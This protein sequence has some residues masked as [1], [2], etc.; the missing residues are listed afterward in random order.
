M[1]ELSIEGTRCGNAKKENWCAVSNAAAS[2]G[3][4]EQER[5]RGGGNAYAYAL[6]PEDQY[7]RMSSSGGVGLEALEGEDDR[8]CVTVKSLM[9]SDFGL[10]RL[11]PNSSSTSIS[12]SC[13]SNNDNASVS[14]NGSGKKHPTLMRS[15]S[16]GFITMLTHSNSLSD[17]HVTVRSLL[18]KTS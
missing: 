9:E 12:T 2:N 18:A 4:D 3:R 14:S 17:V 8:N 1:E 13:V 15:K 10:K 11:T 5:N 6:H 7:L 16:D